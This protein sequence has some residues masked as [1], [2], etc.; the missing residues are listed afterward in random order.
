MAVLENALASKS[1]MLV[2]KREINEIKKKHKRENDY[3]YSFGNS[4]EADS[5]RNLI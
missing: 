5:K 1:C 2:H 4:E 3:E